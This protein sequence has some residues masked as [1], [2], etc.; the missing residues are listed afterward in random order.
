MGRLLLVCSFLL[1]LLSMA[2]LTDVTEGRGGIRFRIRGVGVSGSTPRSL[3]GGT[4][5]AKNKRV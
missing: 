5:A 2:S 1:V 4:W 3:S